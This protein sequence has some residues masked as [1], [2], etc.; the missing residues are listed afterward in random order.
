VETVGWFDENFVR[1]YYEDMD[2]MIRL[3]IAGVP[4]V[5]V[6][7]TTFLQDLAGYGGTGFSAL[8]TQTKVSLHDMMRRSCNAIYVARKWRLQVKV[9]QVWLGTFLPRR[10]AASAVRLARIGSSL[11]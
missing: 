5:N 2:M 7:N 3:A 4:V 9:R 6:P 11:A 8:P 10:R 1:P